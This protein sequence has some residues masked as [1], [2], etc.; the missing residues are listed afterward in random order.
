MVKGW[1]WL[2]VVVGLLVLA[3]ALKAGLVAFAGYVLIG[4]YLLS[5]YLARQWTQNL[6]VERTTNLPDE[7]APLEVG[8]SLTVTLKFRNT[9][10]IPIGWVL[11]EEMLPDFDVRRGRI[12]VKGPR[13]QVMFLRPLQTKTVKLKFTF[14]G[15]G[16]YPIGPTLAE[17]G[18]VFGFYRRHRTLSKP[19]YVMV[20]PVIVSLPSYDFASKRPIGEIR[21]A[22][23]L[24]EDPTRTA[25]VRPYQ[26]G[27]P[28]QRVHWRATARTGVLHSRVYEPTSLAGATIL[29]DFHKAGYPKRGEPARSDLAIATA[30][31]L[32]YAVSL[33]NQQVGLA[34]NGRDA[35]ERIRAEALDEPVETAAQS[36]YET[37]GGARDRFEL[38][39]DSTR[40][41]PVV[42][43]TR[44][45]FDQFQ[46]IRETLARLELTDGS[47]FARMLLEVA[48]RLPRDATLVA[49]LPAV[50]VETAVALG[51]MR[52]Q[53]FAI[54][55]VLIGLADDGTDDRAV[56]VGR[57]AAEGVRDVRLV[58]SEAL[59]ALLGD[60]A[61]AGMPADYG[62]QTTLA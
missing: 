10:K 47:T 19:V 7:G 15:R 34:S 48:P 49:V 26:L 4:V 2:L 41:R 50:S 38:D 12:A 18:D 31:A 27:D 14:H 55:A 20:L 62:F 21:L 3:L 24:F 37:R 43:G 33:L 58:D 11:V 39:A 5:R 16:Y 30:C 25:G 13:I 54:S 28:L 52:R 40:L 44:R 9:G 17:T 22:N 59:L 1:R 32:A 61:A 60:R 42:V 56:A 51:T 8:E 36:S 46:Q 29:I 57:L 6:A 53:G 35:S 45:G 23:R